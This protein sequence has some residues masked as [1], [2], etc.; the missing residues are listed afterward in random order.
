MQH[1]NS[2]T[3]NSTN[4]LAVCGSSL[5]IVGALIGI[6]VVALYVLFE[7]LRVIT[8]STHDW[9]TLY[10]VSAFLALCGS[11]LSML[12]LIWPLRQMAFF[13]F[14]LGIFL[15]SVLF[16]VMLDAIARMP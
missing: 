8:F 7:M 6:G 16:L 10:C 9:F 13:G 3:G 1:Q 4:S 14:T 2:G 11:A 15:E 12:A 5:S